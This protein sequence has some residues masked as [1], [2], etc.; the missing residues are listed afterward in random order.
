MATVAL[1]ESWAAPVTIG[2]STFHPFVCRDWEGFGENDDFLFCVSLARCWL[3]GRICGSGWIVQE[4]PLF[5]CNFGGKVWRS[6]FPKCTGERKAL[7]EPKKEIRKKK[8]SFR[9]E[10]INKKEDVETPMGVLR[11]WSGCVGMNPTGFTI[12][13]VC[14]LCFLFSSRDGA[15]VKT[16]IIPFMCYFECGTM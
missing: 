11:S 5:Y 6:Q 1:C 3:Q 2:T 14:F 16:L 15:S 8:N 4:T 7:G 10:R 9:R 13:R 12:E